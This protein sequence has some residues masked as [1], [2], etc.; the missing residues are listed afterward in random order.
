VQPL[1]AQGHGQDAVPSQSAG[2]VFKNI[3]QLKAMPADQLMPAMQ[4]MSSSLGVEC[5]FCH[6]AGKMELDDKGAKKTAREMM[7]MQTAI[8]KESFRGQLQ[9]TCFSCHRG[10]QR[11]VNTPPVQDSDAPAHA[12]PAPVAPPASTV[13]ADQIVEKY[14]TALGGAD[15]LGKVTSRVMKGSI[16][17]GGGE[18]PIELFTKAPNKRVSI[19]NGQS[20]T[21]FDGTAGWMGNTGKPAREMSATEAEAAGL[22]AEFSLA[23][24]LKEIFPQLRRGRPETIAGVECET[25]NGSRPGRPPVRLYFDKNSG[26]LLRMVRYAETPVGR[27][28]TQ[29]D[30]A[31]YREMDGVK[32]PWRWTLSRTNGRFTIQVTAATNNVAIEDAKFAKPEGEV[33]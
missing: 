3:V 7:A 18:T 25:L 21:A 27:N 11:P 17:V 24:R 6:V 9:V 33:K 22:D 20:Y 2:E 8:N 23:L 10:A 4:F 1:H 5:A 26:L 29:I 16:S 32:S 30:Y 31:D 14:V 13:T 28:A 15:A 12:A 19:S